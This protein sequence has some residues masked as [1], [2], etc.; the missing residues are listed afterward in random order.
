[1]APEQ[2]GAFLD[3]DRLGEISPAADLY[4]LGLVLIELLTGRGPEGP[5]PDLPLPRAIAELQ[6]RRLGPI[7]SARSMNPTVPF[8]LDAIAAKCLAPRPADRYRSAEA[9]AG[10]LA[11]F[12]DRRPALVAP[13]PSRAERL[14][15]FARRH[16]VRL[17]AGLALG[18]AG[19][20]AS[21]AV[22]P[23]MLV[24]LKARAEAATAAAPHIDYGLALEAAGR[25]R[26][27]RHEFE[28][29]D[30]QH[31]ARAAYGRALAAHRGS[32]AA[33][34][35]YG[36]AML[37]ARRLTEA[38][39]QFLAARKLAPRAPTPLVGQGVIL[40]VFG[41][42]AEA[43]AAYDKARRLPGAAEAFARV[44]PAAERPARLHATLGALLV[45][46]GRPDDAREALRMAARLDPEFPE[47]HCALALLDERANDPGGAFQHADDALKLALAHPAEIPVER[48]VELRRDRALYAFKW[49]EIVRNSARSVAEARRADPLYN[50]A[51]ADLREVRSQWLGR[52]PDDPERLRVEVLQANVESV[53][54]TLAAADDPLRSAAHLR[55]AQGLIN[56]V[57]A[58]APTHPG[59]L[60]LR[61]DLDRS[62]AAGRVRAAGP[63]V[64]GG[65]P[66]GA[67]A[68][69]HQ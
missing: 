54:G 42:T 11:R 1:M 32:V 14:R 23:L 27:A 24:V 21:T 59:A 48:R 10:D 13:N 7:P 6:E 69:V 25:G 16:R 45:E 52:R 37:K 35:G 18:A 30:K 34:E 9:L 53:L 8:A 2:L 64:D 26:E 65:G 51:L 19:L 36:L 43:Q 68:G 20:M 41:R 47:P 49:A 29:A 60:A 17:A 57:L 67:A 56:G 28:V 58:I 15:H 33:L 3:P 40:E 22:G 55:A 5:D 4:A 62:A 12:L 63:G 66:A 39:G 38:D 44:A 31:D 46:A 61:A 50:E